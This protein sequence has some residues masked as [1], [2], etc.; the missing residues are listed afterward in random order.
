MRKMGSPV[1]SRLGAGVRYGLL[2][3][4]LLLLASRCGGE[5]PTANESVARSS[6]ALLSSAWT[7]SVSMSVARQN[8]VAALLQNGSVLVA[9]GHPGNNVPTSSAEVYS[10]A[11]GTWTTVGSMGTARRLFG[12]CT[13]ANGEVLVVGGNAGAGDVTSAELFNPATST[14]SA[15]GSLAAAREDFSMTCLPDGRVLVAGGSGPSGLLS[16]AEVYSPTSGAWSSAGSMP[17]ALHTQ[18]AALLNDGRV[19]I[20]G[21]NNAAGPVKTAAI[22][23]PSTNSWTAT[24]SMATARSFYALQMLGDGRVLAAGGLVTV[25]STTTKTAEIY[26]PSMGTWTAAANLNTARYS[27]VSAT[28]AAGP[29]VVGGVNG[30]AALA[31]SE[32]YDSVH[33]TWTQVATAYGAVNQTATSMTPACLLVAGGNTGA[34]ATTSAQ[35][36]GILNVFAVYAQRSVTLGSSDKINGGDVGVAA[37]ASS[38]FGTQLVVGSSTTVQR[39]HNLVA[40]SVSLGSQ[41]QVGDVQT[42]SLTNSGATLGTQASYPS[43]MPAPP[44]ALGAGPG[45]SNVTVPAFTITTLN[46]GAYGALSVTGTV[47]LNA[48]NYTFSSVTLA[49]QAHLAGVSGT[50]TVS[51]AGTFQAGNS[52]SISSPG[53]TPAGQL[54]ISVAGYDSGTTPAFSIGT[55]AAM[56]AVLLAPHGTLSIGASTLATGAFSGFDVKLGNGVTITYQSGFAGGAQKGT[57]Q[58]TGYITPMMAAAPLVGP[59]P[60]STVLTIAPS[61]PLSDPQ[62]LQNFLQALSDPTSGSFQQFLSVSDFTT[63]F[64]P[65]SGAYSDLTA[66]AKANGFT[67]A[68]SFPNNMVLGITGTVATIEQALSININYYLRPD[69]SQFYALDR[70]PSLNLTDTVQRIDNLENS[71]PGVPAIDP[72][73]GAFLGNDFRNAYDTDRKGESGFCSGVTGLTGAGQNI[74]IYVDPGLQYFSTDIAAYV[75]KIGNASTTPAA[76]A[77]SV[78]GVSTTPGSGENTVEQSLD[79]EMANAMAPAATVY[80]FEGATQDT[81]WNAIATNPQ[82]INQA[83]SSW[84]I[85]V[86]SKFQDILM[87]LAAQ[88][89]SV[90]WASGD[91]GAGPTDPSIGGCSYGSPGGQLDARA[92]SYITVVGGTQLSLTTG[93]PE[94]WQG[95]SAWPNSGGGIFTTQSLPPYQVGFT[96]T[97]NGASSTHRNEPDVAMNSVNVELFDNNNST[98]PDIKGGTS[99]AAPL[100]AGY[101]ALVN[102]QAALSGNPSVGY[103]NPKLYAI[104]G[105]AF[106]KVAFNDIADNTVDGPFKAVAGYDLVTGLGTPRC[107]LIYSL[108]GGQTPPPVLGSSS[109]ITVGLQGTVA[110]PDVCI[111]GTGFPAN[112]TVKTEYFGVPGTS[113]PIRGASGTVKSDGTIA[114]GTDTS[115]QTFV[116]ACS[117]TQNSEVVTATVTAFDSSGNQVASANAAI[118]GNFWCGVSVNTFN[119]GCGCPGGGACG[120][121]SGEVACGGTCCASGQNCSQELPSSLCC[122]SGESA[123]GGACCPS[124]ECRAG[125][126]CCATA[127]CNG[128]CCNG[129][130]C[131]NGSCCF[132]PVDSSGNCCGITS[133]VCSGQCCGGS[134]TTNGSCCATGSKACGTACCNVGQGQVCTNAATSTCGSPPTPTLFLKDDLGNVLTVLEA[135]EGSTYTIFGAGFPQGTVTVTLTSGGSTTPIGTATADSTQTFSQSVI[136]QPQQGGQD[137]ITATE[138]S[139]TATLSVAVIPLP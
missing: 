34:S 138:G 40:P 100:W 7:A 71:R 116:Q 76:V 26:N 115:T 139:S 124:G 51:V 59:V 66:W 9:G 47:Y 134:C 131:V 53:F 48:G 54:L 126:I 91:G 42:N 19:L 55:G 87:E 6:S 32:S 37:A 118:P 45:G 130:S 75:S 83:S 77:V 73:N 63:R 103:A 17:A 64:G 29:I 128:A 94:Q 92:V 62:G 60:G 12:A 85:C 129:G 133:V 11:T 3:G 31:T 121:P 56:S 127:L 10:P 80:S 122:P 84:Q 95:E 117:A 16:S 104:G 57:Q 106:Y 114:L 27:G 39:N 58:L 46:P 96:N 25:P 28:L 67:I 89:T 119:G 82:K 18:G 5:R 86:D 70:Q 72:S 69:G 137:T 36:Y 22:W 23:S 50:A 98:T 108:V 135:I 111:S 21:G 136:F 90:F 30:G 1:G 38:A 105:S 88:G 113:G 33:N 52:V 8:H 97:T 110:G 43:S 24:G 132:G 93:T 20:A 74:G 65:S 101:I 2:G 78:D 107:A 102:Q 44:L 79:I 112:A 49:N 109:G 4:T 41:A 15:T 99:A 81:T 61:L 68:S 123:C 14:W 35:M 13:L 125:G 120:C